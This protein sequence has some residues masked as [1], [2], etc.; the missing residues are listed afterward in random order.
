VA[1]LLTRGEFFSILAAAS[2]SPLG[3]V[4]SN[5]TR[6]P[7]LT[8]AAGFAT[9]FL[10]L[11][12]VLRW[13]TLKA[14][15]PSPAQGTDVASG[16]LA[17]A[18]L[19]SLGRWLPDLSGVALMLL[20]L[21]ASISVI[22][23]VRRLARQWVMVVTAVRWALVAIVA[24]P[25][26]LLAGSSLTAKAEV[27]NQDVIV[28]FVD[29]YGS[30][31][32]LRTIYGF[33][34]DVFYQHLNEQG[35]EVVEDARVSYT[36]TYASIASML[37][38]DY[39]VPVGAAVNGNLREDLYR[40]LGGDNAFVE[41]VKQAG[42]R[43]IH[44]ESG[45]SGTQCGA[46]VD[47]CIGAHAIDEEV[48][49]LLERTIF[50]RFVAEQL[51]H[52]FSIGALHTVHAMERL[53]L[54]PGVPE[55]VFA[56]VLVPHP[57]LVL[58]RDCDVA[59]VDSYLNVWAPYIG[60]ARDQQARRAQYV[61]QVLCANTLLEQLLARESFR[62]AV[63]AIV[64]DHGPDSMGQ[65]VAPVG[66]WDT[67]QVEERLGSLVAVRGCAGNPPRS[68]QNVLRF[69]AACI[70]V[71]QEQYQP[72]RLLLVPVEENHPGDLVVEWSR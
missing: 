67:D 48:S 68:S 46:N 62:D 61:E 64:G 25:L 55:F 65:L 18:Y 4:A 17:M 10:A 66:T 32:T 8:R 6:S 19:G 57:P 41:L 49:L 21:V 12:L 40:R 50:G 13:L 60:D 44:V 38:M 70:G 47:Q 36:M 7:S 15:G 43:Y 28:V 35:F 1:I 14:L 16:L 29:G 71:A 5:T 63:V 20:G 51:G 58:D 3:F 9:A 31:E 11:G 34:N 26:I 52:S 33:D 72:W 2:A 53:D 45:W 39:V 54:D 37:S 22:F 30:S 24:G 59:R 56:H 23:V 27:P 69:V 42:Y